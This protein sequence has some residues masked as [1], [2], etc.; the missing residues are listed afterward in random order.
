MTELK[1]M[2]YLDIWNTPPYDLV[3]HLLKRGNFRLGELN[4]NLSFTA[5]FFVD[6]DELLH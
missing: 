3:T 2:R 6:F 1:H 5:L 4:P